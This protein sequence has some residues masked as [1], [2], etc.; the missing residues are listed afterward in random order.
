M[1][2]DTSSEDSKETK[3]EET[4]TDEPDPIETADTEVQPEESKGEVETKKGQPNKTKYQRRIDGLVGNREKRKDEE[5]NTT[6]LFKVLNENKEL[7][8]MS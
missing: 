6:L 8:K 4:K 5:M 7:R 1:D 2:I 3:G